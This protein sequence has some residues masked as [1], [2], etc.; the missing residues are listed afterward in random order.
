VLNKRNWFHRTLLSYLPIFFI[1]TSILFLLFFLAFSQYIK[2]STIKANQSINIQVT[3]SIE[4]LLKPIDKLIIKEI[5]MNEN[6]NEFFTELNSSYNIYQTYRTLNNIISTYPIVDSMYLF[7]QSDQMVLTNNMY[8]NTDQFVD[9]DFILTQLETEKIISWTGK[10]VYRDPSTLSSH[11]VVSLVRRVPIITGEQGLFVVNIRVDSIRQFTKEMSNLKINYVNIVDAEE[12]LI[13]STEDG[14][15]NNKPVKYLT[16]SNSSYLDWEV[17]SGIKQKYAFDFFSSFPYIWVALGLISIITGSLYIV[18]ITKRNYKPIASIVRHINEIF[19]NKNSS[20]V[21][22]N[23]DEMHVISTAINSLQEHSSKLQSRFEE[24]QISMRRHYF[25]ELLEG[26]RQTQASEWKSDLERLALDFG[27][28]NRACIAVL[29]IDKYQDFCS[30]Y[31]ENDQFLLKFVLRSVV[32]EIAQEYKL[33]IWTEYT[34]GSHLGIIFFLDSKRY[35]NNLEEIIE[36]VC[37]KVIDWIINYLKF[38]ATI[39][40]GEFSDQISDFPLL[41]EDAMEA[42]KYKSLFGNSRVIQSS[43]IPSKPKPDIFQHIQLIRSTVQRYKHGESDWE[44]HYIELFHHIRIGISSH[45][46]VKSI[47]HYLVYYLD[48]EIMELSDP[49]QN[50]WKT[51]SINVLNDLLQQFDTLEEFIDQSKQVLRVGYSEISK[52]RE[53]GSNHQLIHNV[54]EYVKEHYSDPDLSLNHLSDKFNLST[55]YLSKLFK[56]EF[57]EKFVDYLVNVRLEKAKQLLTE[58][59]DSIQDI[60]IKVGYNHAF[61]FIRMF[62]NNEGM[63]PGDYRK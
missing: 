30:Q 17:Q 5:M 15:V 31:S 46:D 60:A 51:D 27:E 13:L 14:N 38:T 63:T 53:E 26:T 52:L 40:I 8:S 50:Y 57:G 6:I 2:T 39:G 44:A 25:I 21:R 3:Q 7:R 54:K 62:K 23:L 45:E 35:P 9:R 41:Y 4:N 19:M 20:L 33:Q 18:Y 42:L 49:I 36:I 55:R 59:Q 37:N 22:D 48:R 16:Q 56:E 28:F 58:T 1:I 10:R 61:S 34:S 24:D 47:L 32:N 11:E 43:D 12:Q 29:E